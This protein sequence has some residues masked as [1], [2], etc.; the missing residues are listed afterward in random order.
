MNSKP[1]RNALHCSKQKPE[2]KYAQR[3]PI[4]VRF[5]NVKLTCRNGAWRKSE[6]CSHEWLYRE[7]ISPPAFILHPGIGFPLDYLDLFKSTLIQTARNEA[8]SEE[9][10]I[11]IC[12]LAE[13]LFYM[14]CLFTYVKC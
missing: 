11:D 5:D 7:H 9:H 6:R 13:K 2:N 12:S 3:T 1:S 10:E 14:D 4:E 8:C